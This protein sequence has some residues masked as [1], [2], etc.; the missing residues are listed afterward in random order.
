MNTHEFAVD[1]TDVNDIVDENSDENDDENTTEEGE[2][3]NYDM[4]AVA[5]ILRK[6]ALQFKTLQSVRP[7]C[8]DV[9]LLL[10]YTSHN[11]W[12]EF[13]NEHKELLKE[14]FGTQADPV[15]NDGK[16]ND[17]ALL[18]AKHK[19]Q[20]IKE[21]IVKTEK[22]IAQH[23]TYTAQVQSALNNA[24]LEFLATEGM[25]W[26]PESKKKND[27][28]NKLIIKC[29][30]Q[31]K[32][33]ET[34]NPGKNIKALYNSLRYANGNLK[35]LEDVAHGNYRVYINTG[36]AKED[37]NLLKKLADSVVWSLNKLF[38]REDALNAKL[39]EERYTGGDHGTVRFSS[40][41]MEDTSGGVFDNAVEGLQEVHD[42]ME[43]HYATYNACKAG[44]EIA[45]Q[46]FTPR[47]ETEW[48]PTWIELPQALK[49]AQQRDRSSKITRAKQQL[50]TART[51][52]SR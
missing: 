38:E 1:F 2:E 22:A 10:Y 32:L 26:D 50:E 43:D 44:Y 27:A 39:K 17:A 20:Q 19:V 49:N 48:F 46:Q 36:N 41:L 34:K 11:S 7:T 45:A 3:H 35:Y 24:E 37:A 28:A 21:E 8:E 12:E 23:A 40:I 18:R 52:G 4:D 33:L 9:E 6:L 30:H 31:L 15:D 16:V 42:A 5:E 29:K 25:E 51:V 14:Y 13:Q 47:Y